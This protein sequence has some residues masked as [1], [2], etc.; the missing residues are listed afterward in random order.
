MPPSVHFQRRERLARRL[1]FVRSTLANLGSIPR[2]RSGIDRSFDRTQ[3]RRSMQVVL[4][5][6]A[7]AG[8]HETSPS[9][10]ET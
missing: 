6:A 2:Q 5:G 4:L 7:L 9:E 8:E 1:L 10:R 3:Q